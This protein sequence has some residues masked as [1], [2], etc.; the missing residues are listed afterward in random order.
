MQK[1]KLCFHFHYE[2]TSRQLYYD[3]HTKQQICNLT[4]Y[5]FMQMCSFQLVV[6]MKH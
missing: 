4:I 2:T 6:D 5:D 3:Y 1:S